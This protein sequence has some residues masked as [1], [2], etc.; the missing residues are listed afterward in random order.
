MTCMIAFALTIPAAGPVPWRTSFDAAAREAQAAG[1]P[2]FINVHAPWCG[3]CKQMHRTVFMDAGLA[4]DLARDAV[5]LS[6]DGDAEKALSQAWG[7]KCF[8]THLVVLPDGVVA[9]RREGALSVRDIRA[10]LT[11]GKARLGAAEAPAPT[12]RPVP[13]VAKAKPRPAGI[14]APGPELADSPSQPLALGGNCPVAM[15]DEAEILPGL[16]GE[17]AV[18]GGATYRFSSAEARRRFAANPARYLPAADGRCVVSLKESGVRRPGDARFP[19]LFG[20]RLYL[21]ASAAARTRFLDDPDRF[22]AVGR[23]R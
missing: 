19:A 10:M 21:F 8:P 3:P 9:D 20:E 12:P 2:L 16:P 15:R 11:A 6:V 23:S 13:A 17:V 5:P 4:R 1:K 7:I 14:A 22:A 18:H